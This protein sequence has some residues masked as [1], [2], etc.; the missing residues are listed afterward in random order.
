MT[1]ET[2]SNNKLIHITQVS[3]KQGSNYGQRITYTSKT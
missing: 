3:V 2:V 1:E